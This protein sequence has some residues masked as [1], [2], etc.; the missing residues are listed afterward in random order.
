MPREERRAIVV[1][2]TTTIHIT[3]WYVIDEMVTLGFTASEARVYVT[4]LE[5]PESTGYEVAKAA[6]LPRA[7]VYAAL[8]SL[9]MKDSATKVA[10]DGPARFVA[11]PPADVFGRIKRDTGR[12]ADNLIADLARLNAP[13]SETVFY[14]LRNFEAIIDRVASLTSAARERVGVSAWS[15][16][17][18]WLAEPLRAAARSG[19][20]VVLNVFGDTDL[21]VGE[22][23]RHENTDHTVGGHTLT[24]VCDSASAVIADLGSEPSALCTSQ[25]AVVRVVEKLLRDEAYLAAIYASHRRELEDS[26]GPHLV[27]LR[28]KLLPAEQAASLVS[29]VGFG[30]DDVASES[31]RLED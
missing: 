3:S 5:Q 4:L 10:A 8:Q 28:T 13:R 16:D 11:V 23:Y 2:K 9:V 14:T 1:V 20:Q 7:N 22:V 15:E 12:R 18:T 30:A 25:P 21:D 29:I 17:M 31:F 6:S 26:F 27:Q 19:C 24:V